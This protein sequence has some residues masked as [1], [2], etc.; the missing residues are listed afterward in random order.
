M[1][2][3]SAESG[4]SSGDVSPLEEMEMHF[5]DRC[6]ASHGNASAVKLKG[7][8][9]ASVGRDKKRADH[10]ML[11]PEILETYATTNL[12][13]HGQSLSANSRWTVVFYT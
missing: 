7:K 12:P 11:P 13:N 10:K 9:P 1:A 8:A 2:D 5:Y 6:D 3:S 4:T